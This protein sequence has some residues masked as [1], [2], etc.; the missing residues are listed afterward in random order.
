MAGSPFDRGTSSPG[1]EPEFDEPYNAW[2]KEQNPISNSAILKAVDPII[3]GAVANQ[4]AAAGPILKSKARRIVLDALPKYDPKQGPLK[5]FLNSHLQG[6]R[7]MA[8]SQSNPVSVP[9]RV[10]LDRHHLF[11]VSERLEDELGRPPD[12]IELADAAGMPLKRIAHVRSYM[13]PVSEGKLS[14]I[15][16]ATGGDLMPGVTL[17]GQDTKRWA[18]D[19]VYQSLPSRDRLIMEHT[20]GLNNKEKLNTAKLAALLRVT[21]AAISQRRAK[22]QQMVDATL[23][24]GIM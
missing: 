14:A 2:L 19:F 8:A 22:I 23:Q 24:T 4:G 18:L 17:P 10:A 7:R 16:E 21:P 13:R 11:E 9:E 6:L 20:L 3:S 1:I 5:K 12:D 15:G